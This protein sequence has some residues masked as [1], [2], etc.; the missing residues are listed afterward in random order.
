MNPLT[1]LNS[2]A[3]AR[4]ETDKD[5][6]VIAR[7]THLTDPALAELLGMTQLVQPKAI[8]LGGHRARLKVFWRWKSRNSR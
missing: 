1:R 6:V 3:G 7:T 4:D 2:P 8:L 5:F